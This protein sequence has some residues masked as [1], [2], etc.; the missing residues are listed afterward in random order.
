[1][2]CSGLLEY[3]YDVPSFLIQLR[4]YSETLVMSYVVAK[5]KSPKR[6]RKRKGLDW[7][8]HYNCWEILGVIM[9]SGYHI[10]QMIDFET[11]KVFI[12]KRTTGEPQ[13]VAFRDRWAFWWK[14]FQRC[15]HKES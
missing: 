3:I 4:R 5:S 6:I 2:F 10:Q 12:L 8:N 11:Q 7:V 14:D 13:P 9:G 1:M 15:F